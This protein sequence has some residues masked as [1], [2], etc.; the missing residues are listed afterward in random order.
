MARTRLILALAVLAASSGAAAADTA[1]DLLSWC[2]P[3]V[4]DVTE[5]PNRVFIPN[6]PAIR[7]CWA[8]F[9]AVQDFG[10][11]VN[12][13]EA[14]PILGACLPP[15]STRTQLIRV[16]VEYANRNPA[17]LNLPGSIVTEQA[18]IGA[19]PCPAAPK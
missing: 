12:D 5:T 3:F 14:T 8:Y 7:S 4:R 19:F 15:N 6:N 10:T 2:G 16:F 11:I 18:L 1:E 13:G 17:K 9:A